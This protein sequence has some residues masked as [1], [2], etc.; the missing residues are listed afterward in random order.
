MKFDDVLPPGQIQTY[1]GEIFDLHNPDPKAVRIVDIATALARI[2]R[3]NGHTKT[4]YSVAQHSV[5]VT[6]ELQPCSRETALYGLLH[7]AAEAYIGDISRPV[8]AIIRRHTEALAVL[9]ENILGEILRSYGLDGT[10]PEEVKAADN[11]IGKREWDSFMTTNPPKD[12]IY[13]WPEVASRNTFLKTFESLYLG[14]ENTV[15]CTGGL[16]CLNPAVLTL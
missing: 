16:E 3:F 7:D 13:A 12:R 5:L 9:E 1:M 2:P 11:L 14:G 10:L 8:K 6:R 15:T 4:H